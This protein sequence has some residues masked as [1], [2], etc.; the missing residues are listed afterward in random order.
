MIVVYYFLSVLLFFNGIIEILLDKQ[1]DKQILYWGVCLVFICFVGLK[2][3]GGTD[4]FHYKELFESISLSDVFTSNLEPLFSC[5]IGFVKAIGGSF[6]LFYF[7]VA[8]SNLALKFYV[9]QRLTPYVF[10]AL[11]I[12]LVGLFFERDND[13]IRQ[14]FSIAFC[15]LSMLSLLQGKSKS[16]VFWN[17]IATLIHYS[18]IIFLSCWVFAKMRLKDKWILFTVGCAFL[19]PLLHLSAVNLLH[20]ISLDVVAVKL[21]FYEDSI[22]ANAV[23]INIGL[24]FR[25]LILM[26][27]MYYHDK[28]AISEK[29]YLILRNGFAFAI[30]LSL[31]FHDMEV[32]AHRLPYVFREFQIFIV[33]YFFTL[34]NKKNRF[35]ILSTV[36]LYSLVIVSRFLMGPHSAAYDSYDNV[37]FHLFE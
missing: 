3:S 15:Y 19:F 32:L 14:G 33:P 24:L 1:R 10:P 22:F 25:V 29:L 5:C 31:V 7:L 21:Q 18:S 27:F 2:T 35:L 20:Y 4:F 36:F 6:Y 37:L 30:I 11:L 13:G 9:F 23:G 16:F 12:Y 34:A 17:I 28:L 8:L 26:L